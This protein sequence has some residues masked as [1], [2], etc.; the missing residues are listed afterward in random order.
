[1]FF[2]I[3]DR[4]LANPKFKLELEL[5]FSVPCHF[6]LSKYPFGS[7]ICAICLDS[8]HSMKRLNDTVY[9]GKPDLGELNLV[10]VKDEVEGDK[11]NVILYF[12]SIYT[13]HIINSFIPSGLV[14]GIC[15]ITM[16][17]HVFEFNERI[18]VS[19]TS[20]LVLVALFSQLGETSVRT[21]YAKI[22]ELWY[23][24]LMAYCFI[25][26]IYHS[27][28]QKSI[29]YIR[30]NSHN[31]DTEKKFMTYLIRVNRCFRLFFILFFIAIT[32]TFAAF[33]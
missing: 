17:F 6:D 19:L 31:H 23:V 5:S 20:V 28:L 24:C 18:M 26:V 4:I 32:F 14:C 29:R 27:A 1:M 15:Y 12:E 16:F 21:S 2:F 9:E 25:I 10:Q 30:N 33:A 3:L 8:K 22:I 7:P 13:F 11:I